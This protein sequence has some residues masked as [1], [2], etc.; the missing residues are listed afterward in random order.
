MVNMGDNRS[1]EMDTLLSVST[2][3]VSALIVSGGKIGVTNPF[4]IILS[5]L[6]IG[7]ILQ[8][9]GKYEEWVDQTEDDSE[10]PS[11][12]YPFAS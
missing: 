12:K 5:I 2:G 1:L 9:Y 10:K 3:I 8:V 4:T 7:G 6:T 11:I